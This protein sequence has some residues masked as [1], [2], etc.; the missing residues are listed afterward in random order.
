VLGRSARS[1][2]AEEVLQKAAEVALER[3]E[4]RPARVHVLLA[5]AHDVRVRALLH[6]LGL[7]DVQQVVDERNPPTGAALS[8]AQAR[9]EL[10]KAA[11]EERPRVARAPVP[12]F[13]R[14]TA[15]ARRAIRAAAETAALLEHREVDP[16]HLLIGCL[17]VPESFA[18]G[19]L[20]PVWSPRMP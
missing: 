9:A 16:F 4:R 7:E 12:A 17:Q 20:S 15:D 18:A 1:R 8:D 19:V 10:V 14:F 2:A 3:G 5:L 11:M 13:E 6:E